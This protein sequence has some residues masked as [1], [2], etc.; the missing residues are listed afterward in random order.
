MWKI[1]SDLDDLISGRMKHSLLSDYRT[2]NN[3]M[4]EMKNSMGETRFRRGYSCEKCGEAAHESG[5]F[6]GFFIH[7]KGIHYIVLCCSCGFDREC[8]KRAEKAPN[9]K[10]F[11][12]SLTSESCDDILSRQI[13]FIGEDL[14]GIVNN[15]ISAGF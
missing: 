9:M 7:D 11:G 15:L 4:N 13:A 8:Q 5:D 14:V 1:R 3:R 10:L 12:L 2:E 6:A